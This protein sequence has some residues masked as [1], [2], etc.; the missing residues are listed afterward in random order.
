MERE[1]FVEQPE[2]HDEYNA[3]GI[4]IRHTPKATKRCA[5][6]GRYFAP[7]Q[8]LWSF[9]PDVCIYCHEDA[10]ELRETHHGSAIHS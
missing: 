7:Y 4:R 8:T 9:I 5:R 1:E 6:C 2:Y 3:A 10:V